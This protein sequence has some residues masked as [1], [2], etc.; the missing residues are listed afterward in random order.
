MHRNNVPAENQEQ[1]YQQALPLPLIDRIISETSFC[2][3]LLNIR[4]T[5]FFLLVPS[6][7]CHTNYNKLDITNLIGQYSE[8]LPNPAI[9]D[10]ELQLWKRKWL[11]VP[12]GN[13]PSSLAKA[14]QVY[15][16]VSRRFQMYSF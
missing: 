4:A 2:F 6:I 14:I 5:K 16:E 10:L 11:N 8:D 15:A 3:N 7:I 1:Y 13:R 12:A 9:I